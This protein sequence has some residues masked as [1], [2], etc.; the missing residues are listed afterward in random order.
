[1]AAAYARAASTAAC[2]TQSRS[3]VSVRSNSRATAPIPYAPLQQAITRDAR[4]PFGNVDVRGLSL[5]RSDLSP[6]GSR[7]TELAAIPFA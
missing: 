3:A 2:R 5:M 6:G 1:M 4:A 7:Y